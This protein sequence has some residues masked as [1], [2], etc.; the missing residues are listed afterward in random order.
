[1]DGHAK[2]A[3]PFGDNYYCKDKSN[4]FD[5]VGATTAKAQSPFILR[6][7]TGISRR[8]LSEYLRDLTLGLH[9]ILQ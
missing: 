9:K 2:M 5:N 3:R 4:V 7:V 8:P 6:L 1:M